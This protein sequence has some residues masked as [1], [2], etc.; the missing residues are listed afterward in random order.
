MM[1]MAFELDAFSEL[2]CGVLI[3]NSCEHVDASVGNNAQILPSELRDKRR[4]VFA[5]SRTQPTSACGRVK[6]AEDEVRV[7]KNTVVQ[8]LGNGA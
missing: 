1:S 4:V 5:H 8:Q 3:D 7:R 6:Q 2:S